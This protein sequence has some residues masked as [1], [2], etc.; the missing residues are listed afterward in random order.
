MTRSPAAPVEAPEWIAVS[1][2]RPCPVCGATCR[3]SVQEDRE[4]GRC[5]ETVSDWPIVAGG[6][7]HRLESPSSSPG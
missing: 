5:F 1:A 3:C 7:L 2:A 6:W 4:F